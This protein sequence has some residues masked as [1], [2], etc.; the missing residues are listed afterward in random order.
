MVT[1]ISQG[2]G[3][4]VKRNDRKVNI[5]DVAR[6][7]N[8]STMTV[9]RIFNHNSKVATGTR[10][11]V[12]KV[13]DELGYQPNPFARGL[14][15]KK[16]RILGLMIFDNMDFGFFQPMFLGVEQEAMASGYDLLIFS[17]PEKKRRPESRSLAMV[18][19]V[20]CFGYTFDNDTIENLDDKGIPYVVIGKRKWNR[21]S[22]WYCSG[23]YFNGFKKVTK[24]LLEMGHRNIAY[25][26]GSASFIVD[27]EKRRGYLSALQEAGIRENAFVLDDAD[28][29]RIPEILEQ[30]KPTAIL[31]DGRVIPM[32]LL[33][34][35][36]KMR[37][38]I[39]R[40]LS[41]VYCELDLINTHTLYGIAGIHE[42]TQINIPRQELGTS[43][44]ILL[45]RL[46]N[47]E[48]VPD[49]EQLIPMVF[50]PGESGAPP[51][52]RRRKA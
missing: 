51:P 3:I 9:S 49:R 21:V 46:I 2:N 11:R 28:V 29:N 12:K 33:L 32:P 31:L 48:E 42:L 6:L 1:C 25:M 5:N 4:M 22:P 40:D 50:V 41:L 7:A 17:G 24:Y 44:V 36:K 19:G 14:V 37:L 30:R 39:P 34:H 26:G 8:V 43:G 35:A 16:S 52:P 45:Q 38:R 47:G 15:S 20:L 27:S 13:I 23:D 18:D 10:A